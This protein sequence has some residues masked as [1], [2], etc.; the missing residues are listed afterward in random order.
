ME[1]YVQDA[2]SA[3]Y[4]PTDLKRQSGGN[5]AKT[6]QSTNHAYTRGFF[7]ASSR[8]RTGDHALD[9]GSSRFHSSSNSYANR[10]AI[11]A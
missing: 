4:A 10:P 1:S 6:T 5:I 7:A 3:L 2:S 11:R 9:A 8:V